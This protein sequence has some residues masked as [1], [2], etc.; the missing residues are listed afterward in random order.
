MQ[1]KD[2]LRSIKDKL[3]SNIDLTKIILSGEEKKLK[4]PLWCD[5][6]E[7][8]EIYPFSEADVMTDE[9]GLSHGPF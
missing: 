7:S 9:T 2:D 1:L 6:F 5:L 8:T 4:L 3:D